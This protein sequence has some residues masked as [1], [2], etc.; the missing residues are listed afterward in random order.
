LR[1]AVWFTQLGFPDN[2]FTIPYTARSPVS[3]RK[4]FFE[5]KNQVEEEIKRVLNQ[6]GVSKFG[7][8][9]TLYYEMP[10]FTN[11]KYHIKKWV[12]DVLEDYRLVTKFNIPLGKDLDNICAI[13]LDMFG[14]IEQEINNIKKHKAESD[15]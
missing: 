14:I 3:G 1:S 8:G 4:I 11:P 6:K 13:K 9:Q 10:F 12:W 2:N 7:V 5:N 15:G